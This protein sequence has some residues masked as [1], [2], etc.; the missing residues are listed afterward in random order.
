MLVLKT[1]G[2]V[3]VTGQ[4]GCRPEEV[5]R[6]VASRLGFELVTETRLDSAI[7][8]EFAGTIPDRAYAAVVTSVLAIS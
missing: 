7:E 1:M 2:L 4:T 5:A 3:T 6:V 8:S